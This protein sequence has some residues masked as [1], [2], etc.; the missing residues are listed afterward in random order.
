MVPLQG[1]GCIRE[2][3]T[4]LKQFHFRDMLCCFHLLFCLGLFISVFICLIIISICYCCGNKEFDVNKDG[5]I[6]AKEFRKAMEAQK[7]FTRCVVLLLRAQ[8]LLPLKT[9]SP[10]SCAEAFV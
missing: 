9:G 8:L 5:V 2:K 6:S 7:V 4:V 3:N 10:P 1:T